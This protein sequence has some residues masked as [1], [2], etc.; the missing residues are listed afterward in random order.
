MCID[1]QIIEIQYLSTVRCNSH[2]YTSTHQHINT[3]AARAAVS[4]A[5]DSIMA[6]FV[7]AAADEKAKE[8]ES[9]AKDTAASASTTPG[10]KIPE[11]QITEEE[12]TAITGFRADDRVVKMMAGV[13]DS[14][15]YMDDS[16]LL[17]FLRAR[18]LDFDKTFEMLDAHCTWRAEW[19]PESGKN[20]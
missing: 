15:E 17:R 5:A 8:T 18:D 13:P 16:L 7:K 10:G 14:D 12:R 1:L 4:A 3:S 11:D 2:T 6:E 19:K 20:L 9:A